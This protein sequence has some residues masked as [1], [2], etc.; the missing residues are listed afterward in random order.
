MVSISE[1][2]LLIFFAA[3]VFKDHFLGQLS[4]YLERFKGENERLKYFE[5][6]T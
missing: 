6:A 2:L 4:G 3:G 5:F 1:I